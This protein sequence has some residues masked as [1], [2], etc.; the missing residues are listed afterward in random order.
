MTPLTRL[1]ER[2]EQ[3]FQAT[4]DFHPGLDHVLSG[5]IEGRQPLEQSAT[6]SHWQAASYRKEAF[7]LGH[8][9]VTSHALSNS[10]EDISDS[11]VLDETE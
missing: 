4:E 10:Y 3:N 5:Y 11:E 2:L 1:E 9:T 6:A 7:H 8:S